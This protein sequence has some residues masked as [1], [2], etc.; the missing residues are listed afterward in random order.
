LQ[1]AQEERNDFLAESDDLLEG[2]MIDD[3]PGIRKKLGVGLPLAFAPPERLLNGIGG[4]NPWRAWGWY[5][6][7]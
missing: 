6:G 3:L 5:R 7:H 4:R 2:G 1:I